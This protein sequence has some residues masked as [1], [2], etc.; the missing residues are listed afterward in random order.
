MRGKRQQKITPKFDA[1]DMTDGRCLNPGFQKT[2]KTPRQ[3]FK[4]ES[5]YAILWTTV[6]GMASLESQKCRFSGLPRPNESYHT[7]D[8]HTY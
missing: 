8:R 7:G 4:Q 2:N 5:C 6:A 1:M 3:R